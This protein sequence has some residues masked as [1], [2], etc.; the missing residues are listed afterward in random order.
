MVLNSDKRRFNKIQQTVISEGFSCID[1]TH[2]PKDILAIDRFKDQENLKLEQVVQGEIAGTT[3]YYFEVSYHEELMDNARAG[4]WQ[5]FV[6]FEQPTELPD[7]TLEP[8]KWSYFFIQFIGRILSFIEKEPL[9]KTVKFKKDKSFNKRYAVETYSPE[10]ALSF[11]TDN[12]R[13]GL[14]NDSD[15]WLMWT[16][17]QWLVMIPWYV[18]CV[19]GDNRIKPEDIPSYI[20]R[21]YKLVY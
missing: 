21:C 1:T 10:S 12:R 16:H 2:L 20:Q 6:A 4:F 5:S 11:F 3:F 13:Q 14:N 8:K 17:K 18:N 19:V 15:S 9:P 7:I